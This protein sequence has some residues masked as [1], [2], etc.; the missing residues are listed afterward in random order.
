MTI[1]LNRRLVKVVGVFLAFTIFFLFALGGVGSQEVVASGTIEELEDK[2]SQLEKEQKDIANNLNNAKQTIKNEIE[3]Q[4][5]LSREIQSVEEQLAAYT[6]KIELVEASIEAL[7]LEID[8]KLAEIDSN[9]EYFARRVRAMYIQEKSSSTMATLLSAKSFSQF[10]NNAEI[11]KR[12]SESDRDLIQ[13]LST[14]KEELLEAKAELERQNEDLNAT[15]DSYQSK[16]ESLDG[17]YAKSKSEEAAQKLKEKQYIEAKNKNAA[18]IQRLEDELDELIRAAG[19]DGEAPGAFAWPVPGWST[20]SSG[21]GWRT[22]WGQKEWH[23]GIDIPAAAG[24][25]IIAS[26]AGEVI[27]VQKANTGYGWRVAI[28]H[29][30]G[31]TTL[32][33]HASRIDVTVGQKVKQGDVIAGV[34]TTGASTGNHLHFEVRINGKQDNPLNYVK[35]PS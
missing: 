33:A 15:R 23:L 26:A 35:R 22:I 28:N 12:I 31:Y 14:Q 3:R 11:M 24:S 13:T 9:E 30:G 10:L 17:L 5:L 29:G 16:S 19:N 18:E 21:Y 1:T 32:Y 4:T 25:N 7:S 20:I 34:G 2:I 8:D 27:V 6:K